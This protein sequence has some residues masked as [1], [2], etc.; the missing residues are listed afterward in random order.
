VSSEQCR[1]CIDPRHCDALKP[2]VAEKRF[3]ELAKFQGSIL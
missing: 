3:G 2:I 1:N